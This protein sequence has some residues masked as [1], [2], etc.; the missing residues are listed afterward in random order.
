MSGRTDGL[1]VLHNQMPD[2]DPEVEAF[3]LPFYQRVAL[4]SKKNIH[5]IRPDAPDDIVMLFGKR[6]KSA[7]GLVT[8]FS[9]DFCRPVSCLAAF[10]CA[11][12]SFF[13]SV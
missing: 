8:T 4:P 1:Q 6:A 11:L 13:G 2:W 7:D 5:I 12:T 9:L 10:G 3:T